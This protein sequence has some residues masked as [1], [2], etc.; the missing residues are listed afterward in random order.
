[1]MDAAARLAIV[2]RQRELEWQMLA[3]RARE[4][5]HELRNL[6]QIAELSAL[7]LKSHVPPHLATIVDEVERV[8]VGMKAE[9]DH[10]PAVRAPVGAVVTA[11]VERLR[12]ACG[13]LAVTHQIAAATTT[14]LGADELELV[15]LALVSD[16]G[17]DGSSIE[18][19][20]RE[21]AIDGV[22]WVELV[23]GFDAPAG[24]LRVVRSIVERAG[25]EVS[26]SERRG[27]GT[28]VSVALAA[29]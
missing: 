20:V 5:A 8:A 11:A 29:T 17:R 14:G 19:L 13:E 7:A 18:L 21:R 16:A 10:P 3:G 22:P 12:P 23:C 9:L 24:E 1:M 25:G 27:G 4:L 26:A 15:V 28:E 2:E 6:I